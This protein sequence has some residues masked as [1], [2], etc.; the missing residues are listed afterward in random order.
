MFD[1]INAIN[2]E[3]MQ[4]RGYNMVKL[5]FIDYLQAKRDYKNGPCEVIRNFKNEC[6]A[7]YRAACEVY[8]AVFD[9]DFV[10]TD[11]DRKTFNMTYKDVFGG[12]I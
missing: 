9:E 6:L 3:A 7:A 4:K 2:A 11:D 1:P 8:E 12:E 10:L 5:A